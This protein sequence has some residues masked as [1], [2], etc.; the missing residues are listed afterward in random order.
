MGRDGGA[1]RFDLGQARREIFLQMGLDSLISNEP[2]GQITC[3]AAPATIGDEVGSTSV[4][5]AI[6]DF[7]VLR[8]L[9]SHQ[10]AFKA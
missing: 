4:A 2:V 6:I 3:L 10:N 7:L 9:H 8:A 1:Y 5:D